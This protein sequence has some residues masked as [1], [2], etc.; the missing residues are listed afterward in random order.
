MRR[1]TFLAG[2][3]AL[4]VSGVDLSIRTC[5]DWQARPPA[6]ELVA[7]LHRPTRILVHHTATENVDDLSIGQ[8]YDLA[9][10]IQDLHMDRN[11]WVDSGQHFTNSRGGVLMEGRW[12]SYA[13]LR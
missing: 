1:R 4:A 11:G 6:G 9:R 7:V 2:V 8:A 5:E 12:G 13:A 3:P 10:W